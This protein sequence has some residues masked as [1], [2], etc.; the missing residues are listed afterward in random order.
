M[1]A[2]DITALVLFMLWIFGFIHI[3][4]AITIVGVLIGVSHGRKVFK[5]KKYISQ[6]TL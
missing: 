2:I 1:R 6:T 3:L 5:T 4:L